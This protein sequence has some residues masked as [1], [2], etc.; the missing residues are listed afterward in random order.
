MPYLIKTFGG[1]RVGF[2]GINVNPR[3]MVSEGNY[4]GLYYQNGELIADPTA[5][6]LEGSAKSGLCGDGVA[7]R[8]FLLKFQAN[9][10]TLAW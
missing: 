10:A 9:P 8:L 6:Y 4:D 3:G 2:I 5:K 1:K 7:Y